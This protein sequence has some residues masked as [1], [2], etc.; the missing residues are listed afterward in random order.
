MKRIAMIGALALGLAAGC[1]RHTAD[2][3]GAANSTPTAVGAGSFSL[4]LMG[5]DKGDFVS[6]QMRIKAV[7]ITGGANVLA[8]A[9]Q[10]PEVDLARMDQAWLLAT[11][12][13]PAG[14]EDVEF[15]VTFEGGIVATATASYDVDARC[16][17]L[18]IAGKINRVAERKHA[19][20]HLDVA[21]S[22]VPSTAGVLL[23]PHFQLVY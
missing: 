19:V 6:A 17:T 9:V 14:V 21:R 5:V 20:I 23:V 11:F 10:T 12:Q 22:F 7:Q 3:T 2:E 13:A 16:Q 8:D 1:G 18:R 15:A 4:R